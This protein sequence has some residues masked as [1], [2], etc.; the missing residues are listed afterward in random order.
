M[1]FQTELNHYL[2]NTPLTSLIRDENPNLHPV[3]HEPQVSKP[4]NSRKRPSFPVPEEDVGKPDLEHTSQNFWKFHL[5]KFA[6][7]MYL[8][9]NPTPRHLH[10][11]SFPGYYI[12]VE[13]D[14]QDYTLSFE[15]IE[16]GITYVRIRKQTK[17]DGEFFRYKLRR[18][19]LLQHGKV[20]ENAE[21][22]VYEGFLRREA[23]PSVFLPIS[24]EFPLISYRTDDFDACGW[25]V[26]AMPRV[27]ASRV[28]SAE[29][30]YWGKHNVYFHDNFGGSGPITEIPPV[31]AVF[32]PSE[33]STKKRVIRSLKRLL[34]VDDSTKNK[35]ADVDSVYLET[36]TFYSAGDG[37]YDVHPTDDDPDRNT[38]WGWLTI[39]EDDAFY[40]QAGMLDLVVGVTTAVSY[41]R[42]MWGK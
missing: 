25:S 7:D 32:R 18:V 15:G 9:T 37:L 2:D 23:I 33:A 36:K 1:S 31:K 27:R 35:E 28:N 22:S 17:P 8:T 41:E 3:G 4:R 21:G 29:L 20:M 26:G 13:G 24:P 11:R 34:K 6:N 38:K 42:F 40:A 12:A 5:V 10:C 14:L 19:R 39:Y 30:K 16:S